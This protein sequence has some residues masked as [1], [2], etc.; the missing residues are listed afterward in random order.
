MMPTPVLNGYDSDAAY[1]FSRMSSS[2]MTLRGVINDLIV[3]L[4]TDELWSKVKALCPVC[5]NPSDSLL[6]IKGAHDAINI[7]SCGFIADRGFTVT[8]TGGK[9]IDSNFIA[10]ILARTSHCLFAYIRTVPSNYS[11]ILGAGYSTTDQISIQNDTTGGKVRYFGDIWGT[12]SEPNLYPAPGFI[13][14]A[15][16]NDVELLRINDVESSY[17]KP[18]PSGAA[19]TIN[20]IYVGNFNGFTPLIPDGVQ[21]AC[22][23]FAEGLTSTELSNLRNRIQTYMVAR[24]AAV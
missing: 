2:D 18:S 14:G 4:K 17:T 1:H 6:D 15:R 3:G 19:L 10:N 23:G 5:D 9:Y 13:G 20:T 7:N 24:G 11:Y 16:I 22:W 21:F 12:P 8:P